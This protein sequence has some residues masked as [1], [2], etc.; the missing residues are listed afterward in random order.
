MHG[1][2]DAL[3][4]DVRTL[5]LDTAVMAYLLD[6]GE[7]KYDLE[8]LALRFLELPRG[9]SIRK[10]VPYWDLRARLLD[11]LGRG[12]EAGKCRAKAAELLEK[13]PE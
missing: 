9:S 5:D 3:D 2:S 1:L 7:R 4:V 8:A 10:R 12:P 6:P 13:K 11:Q